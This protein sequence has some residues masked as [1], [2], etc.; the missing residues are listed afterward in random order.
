[1]PCSV[2]PGV[3]AKAAAEGTGMLEVPKLPVHY[4][5]KAVD[6]QTVPAGDQYLQPPLD[7]APIDSII[8]MEGTAYLVHITQ[9]VSDEISVNLLA[10]LA[11]LAPHLQV[12]YVW[13]M[14]AN[15]W[16]QSTF[17]A[18]VV[19]QIENMT[20]ST[21]LATS[22]SG[23]DNNASGK[24]QL[25]SGDM[26]LLGYRLKA[27]QTQHKIAIPVHVLQGP[28]PKKRI[29]PL[30]ALSNPSTMTRN[31]DFASRGY[32]RVRMLLQLH[33]PTQE[34]QM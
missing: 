33:L 11:C 28:Q 20:S 13:A 8:I 3:E 9:D 18:K 2:C 10:V 29:W 32:C 15:M 21:A 24:L 16:E 31:A 30:G 6:L 5:D 7:F 34:K 22:A 23:T 19:P 25:R 14:P 17:S 1:M 12:R 27:C 26:E 4:I